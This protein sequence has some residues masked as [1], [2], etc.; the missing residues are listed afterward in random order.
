M[1]TDPERM[2]AFLEREV[3][4]RG[5]TDEDIELAARYYSFVPFADLVDEVPEPCPEA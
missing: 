1:S 4:Y 3:E 5:L 2:Q